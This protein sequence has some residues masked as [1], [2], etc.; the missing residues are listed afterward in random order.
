MAASG[1]AGLMKVALSL[2]HQIIPQHLHLK[3]LNPKFPSL[4]GKI[5]IPSKGPLAWKGAHNAGRDLL[6][7]VVFIT[8]V[9]QA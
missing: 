7:N 5:T 6:S 8:P 1:V 3:T 2:Q 4:D 9:I